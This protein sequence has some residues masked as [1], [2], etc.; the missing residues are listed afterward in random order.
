MVISTVVTQA[1]MEYLIQERS[2]KIS[3]KLHQIILLIAIFGALFL[4]MGAV[5]RELK[6]LQSKKNEAGSPE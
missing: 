2:F 6:I 1:I 3:D 5:I 4:S